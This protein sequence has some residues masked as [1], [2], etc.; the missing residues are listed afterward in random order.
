MLRP[1]RD[2][3]KKIDEDKA[4]NTKLTMTFHS[5]HFNHPETRAPVYGY[6]DN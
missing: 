4:E 5:S 2:L 3:Q 1:G 6:E